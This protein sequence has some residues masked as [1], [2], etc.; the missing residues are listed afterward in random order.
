MSR[1]LL[2]WT[3]RKRVAALPGLTI[4]GVTTVA[5]LRTEAR[6]FRAASAACRPPGPQ[7]ASQRGDAR[8]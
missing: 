8:G 3:V 6:R 7:A 4:R 5:G 2:E 1:P